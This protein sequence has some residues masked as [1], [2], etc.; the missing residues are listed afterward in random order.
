MRIPLSDRLTA[1]CKFI[2]SGDRVAD[3]GCDHGYLSIYL[4]Q[5]NIC[6]KVIAMDVRKGPLARAAQ[7]IERFGCENVV[8]T[9]LSDGIQKLALGEAD[10]FVCAGMGGRLVLQILHR[11][12]EKVACMKQV[13]LQPQSELWLVRRMLSRWGMEIETERMVFEEGKFYPMMR[14]RPNAAFANAEPV[15]DE[16]FLTRFEQGDLKLYAEELYGKLLLEEKN[17]VLKEYLNREERLRQDVLSVLSGQD[18]ENARMRRES[19]HREFS[20]IEEARKRMETEKE[21]L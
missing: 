5:R 10:G 1:C 4:V 8:E 21:V 17:E 3:V 18:T 7:T 13:I 11:D 15:C 2:N 6:Q 14:I 20:L 16:K 12:K 9:R 19:L